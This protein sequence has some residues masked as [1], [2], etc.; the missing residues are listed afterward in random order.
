MDHPYGSLSLLPPLIAIVLA[1]I[2]RRAIVALLIGVFSGALITAGGNPLRAMWETCEVQLWPTLIDPGKMRVFAF[3]L[4]MG[5]LVGVI[6]RSGGMQGLVNVL[7]RFARGRRSGQVT[8]WLLGLIV[9]FDDYTNT[10]L[11]GST[12]RGLFDRLKISREKLAYLVDSTAAP[13]ASLALLS[14]W[15]AVE[16]DYI[17]DGLADIGTD[18]QLTAIELF[19]ASIPYRF[20]AVMAL[21]FVLMIALTGRDF[22]P[23]WKAERAM[24][25]QPADQTDSTDESAA[26]SA[27][28]MPA[29]WYN[30]V[31]PIAVTLMVVMWLLYRSGKAAVGEPEASLQQIVGSADSSMALMYGALVGI[32]TITL[33]CRVQRLLSNAQIINAAAAGMKIVLPAIM[34]LWFASALSRMTGTKSVDGVT[35]TTPY[36][37]KDH[38]LYTA[39]YLAE[40]VLPDADSPGAAAGL[41]TTIRLLPT[42]VFLL[43]AILSFATGTSFG[44]MGILMPMAVTLTYSLLKSQSATVDP[45]DPILLTSI[46][47]VLSGAVFGDHCSP[48]SDTTILSSQSAAVD[49][50]AHVLT[51]LPYALLVGG[52]AVVLGTLPVGWGVSL[53]IL[54]PLQLLALAA[55]LQIFGKQV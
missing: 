49:H 51:Q 23:M 22:G 29:R 16:L 40:Q 55:V 41:T 42:V 9:F 36:E 54:L 2:T 27:E 19:I 6:S 48:I 26:A 14:T 21:L 7:S 17:S 47:S 35:T 38:R 43:A 31:L 10:I 8:T 13:V 5:A 4:L 1:I 44:T 18:S 34:I 15:I 37:F 52:V 11:L 24:R 3:T 20:Y 32:C 28:Q 33:L 39:D 53:W 50:M 46:A 12:L 30:A 45:N 25:T